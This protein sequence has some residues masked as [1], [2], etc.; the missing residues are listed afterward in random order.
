MRA[1]RTPLAV[2]ALGLILTGCVISEQEGRLT[3]QGRYAKQELGE[4]EIHFASPLNNGIVFGRSALLLLVGL[5]LFKPAPG[6]SRSALG[7]GLAVACVG[8]AGWLLVRDLPLLQS[9]RIA[10]SKDALTL[11]IPPEP[12]RRLS[13]DEIEGFE[14]SGF[15]WQAGAPDPFSGESLATLPDWRSL[16]LHLGGEERLTIDVAPLSIEQRQTLA[17]AI[18]ARAG[19]VEIE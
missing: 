18:A 15:T 17:N 16:E 8:A 3:P 6:G 12:E 13:W 9:Y 19:L 5:W 7:V 1:R 11:R 4:I 10:A 14:I 2:A